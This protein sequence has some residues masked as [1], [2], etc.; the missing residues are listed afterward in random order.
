MGYVTP[1]Q[2]VGAHLVANSTNLAAPMMSSEHWYV[3][4]LFCQESML[5]EMDVAGKQCRLQWCRNHKFKIL[6][7]SWWIDVGACLKLAFQKLSHL[8][9][10]S[11]FR[12]KQRVFAMF[13]LRFHTKDLI[14]P[15][16]S[17]YLYHLI[18]SGLATLGYILVR[19]DRIGLEQARCT[20]NPNVSL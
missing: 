12:I 19:R 11:S 6:W 16:D 2:L 8:H 17:L 13:L 20:T 4:R 7:W 3:L 14:N 10:T 1:L 15:N 5:T 9:K 18:P